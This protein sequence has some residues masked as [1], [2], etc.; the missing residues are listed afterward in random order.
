MAAAMLAS[1]PPTSNPS[2]FDEFLS[3]ATNDHY[4]GAYPTFMTNFA[5]DA[6]GAGIPATPATVRAQVVEATAQHKAVG[7]IAFINGQRKAPSILPPIHHQAGLGHGRGLVHP[8][9]DARVLG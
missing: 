5:I 6:A 1:T 2:T 8:Q 4:A 3:I 7:L 9:Q